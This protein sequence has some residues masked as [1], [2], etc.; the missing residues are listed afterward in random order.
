MLKSVTQKIIPKTIL[1]VEDEILIALTETTVLEKAGYQV[2][3]A[4][5]R[6]RALQIIE[7]NKYDIDLVLMDIDLGAQLDGSEVARQILNKRKLP[8][9]FLTAHS[10]KEVMDKIDDDISYGYVDKNANEVILLKTIKMALNLFET[11][12]LASEQAQRYRAIFEAAFQFT[13]LM[14][15]KGILLEANETALNFAGVKAADIIGLPFWEAVWW[16]GNEERVKTLKEAIARAA[17]GEFIR[18]EVELQ[19]ACSTA[20]I[21]F[22]IKPIFDQNGK[23]V[24]L[25]PEGRD[26]T[27]YKKV[28]NVLRE[29]EKEMSTLI[30]NFPGLVYYCLNDQNWT[31]KFVS[32]RVAELTG[33]LPEEILENRSISYNDIIYPEDREKV[34]S[35]IQKALADNSPYEIEYRILTK[36]KQVKYVLERGQGLF[37]EDGKLL[38]LQGFISDIT[39][40]KKAEMELRESEKTFATF[41][42][43]NSNPMA[44]SDINDGIF[45]N[46]NKAFTETFGF[47]KD[48]LIGKSSI[49]LP[50]WVDSQ[51]R[52]KAVKIVE[53]TGRV[54]NFETKLFTKNKEVRHVLF[55]WAQIEIEGKKCL[56][57]AVTDITENNKM[58]EQMQTMQKLESIGVLAGGIAHDFNNLLQGI[59]GNLQLVKIKLEERPAEHIEPYID[60][61]L[62][63]FD[64]ASGLAKQ[65][66]TYSKGGQPK[67]EIFLLQKMLPSMLSFNLSGAAN[68]KTILDIDDDLWP[69]NADAGQIDQVISNLI[70]NAKQAMPNGGTITL[71]AKNLKEREVHSLLVP[72]E[73]IL[74]SI[75]DQG[76][77]ISAENLQK[78]FDPFFTT[79]KHGTGLGLATAYSII[80]KHQGLLLAESEIGQGTTFKIYLPAK[81][82]ANVSW[83]AFVEKGHQT[84]HGRILLMD[85]DEEVLKTTEDFLS[86]SGFEI[87][88]ASRG[89]EAVSLYEKA[90][91]NN[92]PFDLVIFDLTIREGLGGKET[93]NLIKKIDPD[94]R[95][96]VASGYSDDPVMTN[97]QLFG[98]ADSLQKPYHFDELGNSLTVLIGPKENIEE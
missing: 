46:I 37:A 13:G 66:L 53:Q 44:I 40:R 77:G 56:M 6:E 52:V 9:V 35:V 23:V 73:Y 1:L 42:Y 97:P 31:M 75:A 29:R 96:I 80:K 8:I 12:E 95:A 84:F 63:V 61:S 69:I 4:N 16:R 49:S 11:Y 30:A 58:K 33:Y 22:S 20:I 26:I 27:D 65:L 94:V 55:S 5:S 59:Y 72:G 83:S 90:M 88:T 68:I 50:L 32:E 54:H 24:L 39:E 98:F 47:T 45:L 91:A 14:T 92:Q 15:T 2:V 76:S 34:A 85:D 64:K 51:D 93:L 48:D 79:K 82:Q 81:P 74:I 60:R 57:S 38:A 43:Q 67:K 3:F 7:N 87:V 41:F 21:D 17:D 86:K 62:A 28:E 36:E 78:I 71:Q 89:E 10:N 70:I 18:Y 19:G 25:I